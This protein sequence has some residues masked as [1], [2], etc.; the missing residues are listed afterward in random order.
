MA[1]AQKLQKTPILPA[2]IE[3]I[4]GLLGFLGIG[5]IFSGRIFTGLKILLIYWAA[6]FAFGFGFSIV[7]VLTLGFASLL[8][9]ILAPLTIIIYFAAPVVSAGKLYHQ[10]RQENK[11]RQSNQITKEPAQERLAPSMERYL[12]ERKQ[13]QGLAGWQLAIIIGLTIA[14]TLVLG[15]LGVLLF[16]NIGGT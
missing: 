11:L 6:I 16:S 13:S 5:W 3:I 10:M 4:G 14:A 7:T 15:S 1:T 9:F 8:Y 12:Q 2:V